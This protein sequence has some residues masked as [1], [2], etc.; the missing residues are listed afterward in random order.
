[1]PTP[2]FTS[3]V[4]AHLRTEHTLE[5]PTLDN[6]VA[7]IGQ[8]EIVIAMRYHAGVAALVGGRPMVLI[9]YTNKV[10]A[11]AADIAG[12]AGHA[13]PTAASGPPATGVARVADGPGGWNAALG[14]PHRW[15][16]Q[17]RRR[18]PLPGSVWWSA[19]TPIA[20]C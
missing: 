1:M 7:T 13:T 6:V 10:D 5:V 12:A 16:D 18:W 4:A 11:L 8:S 17:R 2:A 14:R 15:C 9:G 3:L 19:W 20:T